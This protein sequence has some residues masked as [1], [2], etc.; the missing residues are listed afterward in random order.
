M[1]LIRKSRGY[2]VKEHVS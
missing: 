2:V 1:D